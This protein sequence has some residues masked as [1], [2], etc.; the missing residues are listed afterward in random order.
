MGNMDGWDIALFVAAGYL[1]VVWLVRLMGR[2]RDQLVGQLRHEMAHE[3]KKRKR[4]QAEA[5]R[6][7]ES[8][9]RKAG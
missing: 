7:G 8:P 6:R 3:R 5:A 9:R 1:A 4:A 2:Q